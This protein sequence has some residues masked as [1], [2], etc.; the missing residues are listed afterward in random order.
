[1][2]GAPNEPMAIAHRGGAALAPENTLV[3]IRR[4]VSLGFRYLET[5]ARATI[6]GEVV[7]IHDATLERSSG[8]FRGAQ[9][10][11]IGA[12]GSS[13]CLNP[14]R[15]P[16]HAPLQEQRSRGLDTTRP[17]STANWRSLYRRGGHRTAGRP[18]PQRAITGACLHRR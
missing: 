15:R 6:D 2:Y 7:C 10:H 13:E 3:A 12:S 8:P 16:Q 17:G 18:S 9:M 4:A 14:S 1:M 5:D 11:R